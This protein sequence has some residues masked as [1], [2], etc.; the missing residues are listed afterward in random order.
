MNEDDRIEGTGPA[1]MIQLIKKYGFNQDINIE[2]GTVTAPPPSLKIKI[3]NMSIELD[4]DD[5][6][7]AEYLT[8]HKRQIK[9][10]STSVVDAMTSAGYTSHTHDI[11]SLITEG[12]LEFTDVLKTG[13]RIIVAEINKGQ[14]YVILDKAVIY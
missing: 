13:D 14:T 7:V 11:T 3:D 5:L 6:I 4:K 9:F 8:K 2:L 1:K 10:T 12:E